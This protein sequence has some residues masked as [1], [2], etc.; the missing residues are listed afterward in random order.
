MNLSMK[1][2]QTPGLESSLVFA[3]TD[4]AGGGME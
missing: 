2:K 4:G 1:E 3:A